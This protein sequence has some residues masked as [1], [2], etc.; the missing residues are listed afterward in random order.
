VAE[1]AALATSGLEALP[2]AVS[3]LRDCVFRSPETLVP[4]LNR[5][6][7]IRV[8]GRHGVATGSR[9]LA[10]CRG[11]VVW[12]WWPLALILV[13]IGSGCRTP[14]SA[15]G[16]GDAGTG[17]DR[18]EAEVERRIQGHAHYASGVLKD[19]QGDS[20]GAL[21]HYLEAAL[22]DRGNESLV[23]QTFGRLV[24][25]DQS[26]RAVEFLDR[27]LDIP[28]PPASY[29]ASLGIA[30][31]LQ[32]NWEAALTA[33]RAALDRNPSFLRAYQNLVA[34]HTELKE[35]EQVLA[36]IRE[37]ARQTTLDPA[38]LA[39]VAEMLNAHARLQGDASPGLREETLALLDRAALLE[40]KDPWVIEVLAGGYKRLGELGKAEA[41]Y[42]DFL[43]RSPQQGLARQNLLEL[44][45]R[46]DNRKD[47]AE[48]LREMLRVDPGNESANYVLG[49]LAFQDGQLEEAR[50]LLSRS[51]RLAP[52]LEAAYYELA[53]V[54]LSLGEHE[55][56]I[57]VL[58]QA[59]SRFPSQNFVAEFYSALAHMRAERWEQATRHFTAAEIIAA[60]DR[61]QRMTHV[62]YF[63][64]GAASERRGDY[65]AAERHFRKCLEMAPDFAE[66]QNY[67]GYMWTERGENLEEARTLIER[68]VAQEPDNPAFLDSLGWVWF[69]LGQPEKA[70][71]WLEKAVEKSE[72]PDSVL[73]DH[74][75]DIQ[76]ELGHEEEARDAWRRALQLDPDEE[77]A[78]KLERRSER[79]T[80]DFGEPEASPEREE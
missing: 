59:R 36:V 47:A 45:L 6:V 52:M 74:L 39:A 51:I 26:G 28:R 35:P 65:E 11:F 37:A 70:L 72:E 24:Q 67:L 9:G 56:A 50:E 16:I 10:G 57:E 17:L 66:A 7:A 18:A 75:G 20:A 19:L 79:P 60:A 63:Q 13:A 58:E 14:Q 61:P 71:P 32:G 80:S 76:W 4:A 3:T 54:D 53:A 23:L 77:I 27:C 62:F 48:L 21:D 22:A 40:P 78:R 42:R 31:A 73:Y 2:N 25:S 38:Y 64:F 44:Y 5:P 41:L 34:I 30:H 55:A 68:A 15:A 12:R 49:S 8:L 33:N 29:F 46:T 1:V 69:Q 43:R